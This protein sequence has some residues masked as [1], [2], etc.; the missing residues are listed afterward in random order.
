MVRNQGIANSSGMKLMLAKCW[1]KSGSWNALS[2]ENL[3]RYSLM[4]A[5]LSL[6]KNH[7][8]YFGMKRY[9]LR[10]ASSAED[11]KRVYQIPF[12]FL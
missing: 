1:A 5:E 6:R 4:M 9:R 12:E 2:C 7:C 3:L 11:Y 10:N 8:R